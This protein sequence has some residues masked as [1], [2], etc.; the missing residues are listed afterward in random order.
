MATGSLTGLVD[1]S[2]NY[3]GNRTVLHLARNIKVGH[4]IEKAAEAFK[5][6]PGGLTFLYH[7]NEVTDDML[8]GVSDCVYACY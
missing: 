2:I 7:G 5:I 1:V 4:A 8:V 3:Q 6:E